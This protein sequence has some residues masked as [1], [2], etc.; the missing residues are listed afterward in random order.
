[1]ATNQL[2]RVIQH[3]RKATLPRDETGLTDGQL[4]ESYID[5]REEAA[6]AALVHRHGAMVWGVCRRILASHHDTED[7]FQATFLVLVRKAAS[8][9]SKEKVANW[10]YGVAHQ[11]ALKARATT[12]KRRGREREVTAVPEP[13]LQHRQL[14]DDLLPLLDQE[15]SR[16]PQ[17]YRAVIVLCDLEGKTRREAARQF[18]LPEGTVATRLSTARTMLAKRLARHGL[19]ASGG[20]LGLMLSQNAASATV[21][22]VVAS[23]TIKAAS[24]FA[25]GRLAASGALSAKAVALSRAVL[26]TML[27]S[28]L[29]IGTAVVMV[30]AVLSAGAVVFT[31][32][33]HAERPADQTAQEQ[34]ALAEGPGDSP[35]R[36]EKDRDK[37]IAAARGDWP[38]WR[39]PNR[40][41]VAHGVTVPEKW[42]RTLIQEW[43][44]PVGKGVASPVVVAGNVYL[45]TRQKD[46]REVVQ[47]LDVHSGESRWRSDPYPAPYK[48]GPGEGSADDRPRST[49]TVAGGRVFTLGMTGTLSCFDAGT[50]KLLWRKDTK[51]APYM[52]SSPLVTNGLCIVHVGDGAKVG[53]LTAFDVK[54]GEVKWCFAEGGCA[55]S[56]SPILVDLAGERQVITYSAWNPCGVSVATGKKLWGVGPG[57]AGMPCTTTV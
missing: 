22:A 53:G 29:K 8:I 32:Q 52:G 5:S 12:A 56:G 6:F 14:W 42:P 4:L 45:L 37:D 43:E 41:G 31:H 55:M 47:C 51:Y 40:D 17:K 39:G 23:T 30:V 38:Q 19:T 2:R 27:L 50:G 46:D 9:V 20:T 7:A 26:K 15:L 25:A 44:V 48:V 10:L 1:M 35:L 36:G 11:T 49:P 13:A 16:L 21:P 33:V 54:T 34:Q 3:L 28:K 57:G 18:N 24:Y